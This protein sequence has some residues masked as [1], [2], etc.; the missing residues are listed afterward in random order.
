MQLNSKSLSL[1]ALIAGVALVSGYLLLPQ[2]G[3]SATNR[4]HSHA[5]EDLPKEAGQSAFA[6]IAEIVT[7]LNANPNTDWSQTD[8]TSLRAHLIDMNALTLASRSETRIDGMQVQ[9]SVTGNLPAINA[10]QNMVPAHA[11]ELNKSDEWTV[12]GEATPTGATLTVTAQSEAAL[13]KIKALGFYGLMATGAHHQPH[14]LAM[15][16]GKS[17]NH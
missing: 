11:K 14:H 10:A 6:A 15:A 4:T 12:T 9:F 16:K 13:M 3:H 1:I 8:I 2:G 5:S 7:L 17:M